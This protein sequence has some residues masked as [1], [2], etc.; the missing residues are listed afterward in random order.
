MKYINNYKFST[1]NLFFLLFPVTFVLGNLF[2]N[3]NTFFLIVFA[4]IFYN[5]EIIKFK[6]N[7]FD[8]ILVIFF[9]F[10]LISLG[11]NYFEYLLNNEIFP[12]YIITKTILYFRYLLLYFAVR[13]LISKKILKINLFCLVSAICATF[14]GLDIFI[15]FIFG[16]D[17]FGIDPLTDRHFSGVFGEELIAGGFLL[18]FGVFCFFLPLVL[19]KNFLNKNMIQIFLF[20]FFMLG[21]ILS[22]NRM[23]FFLFIFSFF[24]YLLLDQE[25]RKYFIRISFLIFFILAIIYKLSLPFAMN[26]GNFYLNGQNL[27]SSIFV[28]DLSEEPFEV[29]QK[30]YVTEIYCA[31][32]N[33]KNNPIFGGGI[34]SYRSV[35]PGCG[36]HPHNYYFELLSDLGVTGLIIILIFLFLLTFKLFNKSKNSIYQFFCTLDEKHYPFILIFLIEFF[37]LRTSGSFFSTN[38]STLI[39]IVLA[40]L[41]SLIGREKFKSGKNKH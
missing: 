5:K 19:K 9:F 35:A 1:I 27:V 26:V 34:R 38:Q 18:K 30:P 4:I 15:Q 16:R 20:I 21:I 24:A 23:P 36:S 31:K 10:T 8:K 13:F 3:L 28:K 2:I 29:W 40:V 39:F 11:I 22:G 7:L 17:I 6:L 14:V 12:T 37:P 33:W 32:D 25:L 41:V